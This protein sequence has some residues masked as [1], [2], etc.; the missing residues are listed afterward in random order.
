MTTKKRGSAREKRT[1][2]DDVQIR[3]GRDDVESEDY[4]AI[5][6]GLASG[7][8]YFAPRMI[9]NAPPHLREVYEQLQQC[10]RQM[11]H[12]QEHVDELIGAGREMG[13]SWDSLGWCLGLTGPGVRK[14]MSDD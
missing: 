10:A 11:A 3:A 8:A 13:A 12:L 2:N 7:S 4:V 6:R 14:R 9:R 5:V 1:V